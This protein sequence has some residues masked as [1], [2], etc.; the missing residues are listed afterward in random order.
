MVSVTFPLP[1]CLEMALGECFLLKKMCVKLSISN[2]CTTLDC[3]Y[4]VIVYH[5]THTHSSNSAI[6]TNTVILC[7]GRSQ[8]D[9]L[10]TP[11]MAVAQ[12]HFVGT[13]SDMS[14]YRSGKQGQLTVRTDDEDN[15]VQSAVSPGTYSVLD[16]SYNTKFYLGGVVGEAAEKTVSPL[17]ILAAMV[18]FLTLVCLSQ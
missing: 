14:V 15:D 5:T 3:C 9:H 16:L 11:K 7:R 8:A 13:Q 6:H 10:C 18:M 1:V 17:F 4:I 12:S 2:M